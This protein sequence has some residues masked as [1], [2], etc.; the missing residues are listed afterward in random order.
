MQ[1]W[2]EQRGKSLLNKEPAMQTNNKRKQNEKDNWRNNI[3]NVW[4]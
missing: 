4:R 2:N 1:K 3:K